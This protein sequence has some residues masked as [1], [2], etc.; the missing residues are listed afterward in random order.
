MVVRRVVANIAAERVADA[1]AFYGRVLDMQVVTDF[2]SIVTFAADRAAA[3]RLSVAW[4]SSSGTPVPDLIHRGRQ[5]RRSAST[6][7][8][9]WIHH[10]V[11]VDDRALGRAPLLR[12]RSLRAAHQ[13]SFA[14]AAIAVSLNTIS[15]SVTAGTGEMSPLGPGNG[16]SAMRCWN[17]HM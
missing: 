8:R 9:R 14:Y 15:N 17:F 2:A 11:R 7:C 3:Q 6:R 16:R 5:P 10:R 4:E 12:P 13:H 1:Q